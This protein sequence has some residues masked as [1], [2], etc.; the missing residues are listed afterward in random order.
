[1]YYGP[2]LLRKGV[3]V[4][5]CE[6]ENKY[7]GQEIMEKN[8]AKQSTEKKQEVQARM[9]C[10]G[11]LL[12]CLELIIFFERQIDGHGTSRVPVHM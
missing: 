9:G 4:G 2:R 11:H 5:R 12:S 6:V 1:M 3:R 8:F 7:P 10:Y